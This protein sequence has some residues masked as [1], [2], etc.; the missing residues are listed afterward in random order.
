ML[1]GTINLLGQKCAGA[2]RTLQ[3]IADDTGAPFS[4][5]VSAARALVDLRL[6]GGVQDDLEERVEELEELSRERTC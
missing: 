6:K 5:R 3:T 4:A 1:E 2:V